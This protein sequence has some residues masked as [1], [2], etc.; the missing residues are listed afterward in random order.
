MP[1]SLLMLSGVI[2][3]IACQLWFA[4]NNKKLAGKNSV[5]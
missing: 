2:G 3:V 1:F 4:Y 5:E